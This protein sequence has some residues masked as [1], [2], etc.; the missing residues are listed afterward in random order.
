MIKTVGEFIS[1]AQS[2]TDPIATISTESLYQNYFILK[3]CML[4]RLYL[5]F[6]LMIDWVLSFSKIVFFNV[7][8]SKVIIR[9]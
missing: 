4:L 1:K 8:M 2:E 3:V 7:N 5:H 9:I 6:S